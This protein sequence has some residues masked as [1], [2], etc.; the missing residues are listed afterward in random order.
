MATR[1]QDSTFHMPSDVGHDFQEQRQTLKYKPKIF[2]EEPG[3]IPEQSLNPTAD[4][5]TA[6][7][8]ARSRL[9]D[10]I[11]GYSA[12]DKALTLAED[13]LESRSQIDIVLDP[14]KDAVCCAAIKR[15]FP[16]IQ[17]NTKISYEMYKTCLAKMN[18]NAKTQTVSNADILTAKTEPLRTSFGG[19]G[20]QPGG[21]RTEINAPSS[22]SPI[23]LEAFQAAGVIALFTLML[24][25]LTQQTA[26]A[27]G[28]HLASA[29]HGI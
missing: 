8:D 4:E 20:T 9:K 2:F 22:V 26:K 27:I 11:N 29:P 7:E 6:I 21:N 25:L 16:E 23:D 12:L 18:A 1:K 13:K 14:V 17:D 10:L 15:C 24:P 5:S 3:Q 28:I 19:M